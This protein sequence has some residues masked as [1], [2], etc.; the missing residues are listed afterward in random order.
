M[1]IP[2]YIL[3]IFIFILLFV[4]LWLYEI[5]GILRYREKVVYCCDGNVLDQ[6]GSLNQLLPDSYKLMTKE[7]VPVLALHREYQFWLLLLYAKKEIRSACDSY[8]R[9]FARRNRKSYHIDQLEPYTRS[10]TKEEVFY[11]DTICH[12]I[13]HCEELEKGGRSPISITKYDGD[14]DEYILTDVGIVAYKI[15]LAAKIVE[16]K[17]VD[18]DRSLEIENIEKLIEKSLAQKM[19]S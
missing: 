14:L 12:F 8:Q 3:E 9:Y 7:R 2:D 1:Y 4:A 18:R 10:T 11:L 16:E 5:C 15:K 17:V 13:L 6:M 19:P